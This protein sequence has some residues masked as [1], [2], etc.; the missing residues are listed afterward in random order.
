MV[1][2]GT[3]AEGLPIGVQVVGQP[4]RDEVVLAV[5]GWLEGRFGGWQAPPL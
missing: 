5:M 1:R 2:V 3:T 4:W